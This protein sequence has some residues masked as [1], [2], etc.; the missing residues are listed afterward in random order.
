MLCP[1]SNLRVTGSP[2][3][4]DVN[5]TSTICPAPLLFIFIHPSSHCDLPI[6]P[7]GTNTSELPCST[8]T[9]HHHA[10]NKASLSCAMSLTA[11]C[12]QILYILLGNQFAPGTQLLWVFMVLCITVFNSCHLNNCF[13]PFIY[14]LIHSHM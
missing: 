8:H 10:F 2:C 14:S 3:T 7:A 5:Y 12:L 11:V 6:G 4:L 13:Y 1:G 9:A